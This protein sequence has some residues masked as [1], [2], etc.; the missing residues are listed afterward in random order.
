MPTSGHSNYFLFF[1]QKRRAHLRVPE[2]EAESETYHVG[3]A[4]PLADRHDFI[5]GIEYNE[6]KKKYVELLLV[7][8]QSFNVNF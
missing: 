6:R 4:Y 5:I 1:L 8:K 2:N 7:Y 3:E